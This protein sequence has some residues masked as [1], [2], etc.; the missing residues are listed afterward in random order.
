MRRVFKELRQL[1]ELQYPVSC[2]ERA[3]DKL[4]PRGGALAEVVVELN[5]GRCVTFL[6]GRTY[7]FIAPAVQYDGKPYPSVFADPLCNGDC[8]CCR[9]LLCG[10]TWGPIYTMRDVIWEVS[11]NLE[12]KRRQRA[13][14]LERRL[15]RQL[16]AQHLYEDCPISDFL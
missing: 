5:T 7:P 6:L 15:A 10:A 12:T 16:V 3:C 2:N 1:H 4:N 11:E 13:T 9:S 8:M 14:A